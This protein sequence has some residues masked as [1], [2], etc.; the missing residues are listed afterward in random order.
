[1]DIC[2]YV[3][4]LFGQERGRSFFWYTEGLRIADHLLDSQ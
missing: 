4:K 1:M 3:L 2:L